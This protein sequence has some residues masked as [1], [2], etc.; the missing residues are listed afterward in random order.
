[1]K[2]FLLKLILLF[3]ASPQQKKLF[4]YAVFP[5]S[6]VAVKHQEK[7]TFLFYGL[8]T[9]IRAMTSVFKILLFLQNL[10]KDIKI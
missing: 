6:K 8:S 4:F 3:V 7:L 10:F 5:A 1:M 9:A 2:S